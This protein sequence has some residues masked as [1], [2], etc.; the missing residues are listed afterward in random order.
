MSFGWTV[1]VDIH[2]KSVSE[3]VFY[4]RHYRIYYLIPIIEF[5]E[6]G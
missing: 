3:G 1:G 4:P 2:K 5:L 6:K